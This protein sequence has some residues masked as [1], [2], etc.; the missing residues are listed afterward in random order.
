MIPRWW[1]VGVLFERDGEPFTWTFHVRAPDAKGAL[2]LVDGRVKE[3]PY[4][5]FV[6]HPSEPL[7]RASRK[8]EVAAA[9]G[10]YRRSWRDPSI[11][12]LRKL[13]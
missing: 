11:G 2:E 3:R 10:P 8:P 7:A 12:H 1:R 9:Y 4:A 5:V 13:L 6:C